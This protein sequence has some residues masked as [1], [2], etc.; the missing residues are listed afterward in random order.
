VPPEHPNR[1]KRAQLVVAFL[2]IVLAGALGGAIGWGIVDTSC[3]ET[4]AVGD[5]LLEAVPSVSAETHSCDAALL[6]GALTGAAL[7]AVGAGI[8]AGLMLRAQSE[9][10]AHPPQAPSAD[11]RRRAPVKRTGSGGSP[12]HT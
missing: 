12:P 8:V 11:D 4:P 5:Q 1:P 2:G 3:T 6:A 10:R 7:A 9:W